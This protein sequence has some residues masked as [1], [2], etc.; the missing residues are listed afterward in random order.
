M[1][2]NRPMGIVR[3]VADRF[4][5]SLM[6]QRVLALD[7]VCRGFCEYYR[8]GLGGEDQCAGFAA[9]VRGVEIGTISVGNLRQLVGIVPGPA[10]RSSFLVDRLCRNCSYLAD[11]CDYMAPVPVRGSSPCGGY[12]LLLGL[13]EAE[14]LT[15][16]DLQ[17]VF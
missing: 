11:G 12:R 7:L 14:S 5:E 13:L 16:E 2:K 8:E 9:V 4:S 6:D 1:K 15:T 3:S 17:T 10:R